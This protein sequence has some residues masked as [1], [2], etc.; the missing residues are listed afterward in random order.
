MASWTASPQP[1][2]AHP[3]VFHGE[4]L[5]EVVHLGAGGDAIRLHLSNAYGKAPLEIAGVHVAASAGG[6]STSAASDRAV[7]FRGASSVV[8]PPGGVATSDPVSL[9]V[10]PR[11]E[12]AV[13]L[14]FAGTAVATT[15]HGFAGADVYVAAAGDVAAA[16]DLSSTRTLHSWFFLSE[17]D[18]RADPGARVVVAFGDSVTD[19]MGSTN[20]S[21][22]RWPDRLS[23][24]LRGRTPRT[25]TSIVNAGIAGNRLLAKLAGDSGLARFERD[26][27]SL[28]GASTVIVMIGLNDL[29]AHAPEPESTAE[30]IIA[31][32]QKLIAMARARG[33]RVLGATLTPF[34]GGDGDGFFLP[35]DEPKRRAVNVWIRTGGAYDAVVDFDRVI[36]DPTHPTRIA[37]AFDSGDHLHPNDAGYRAMADAVDLARLGFE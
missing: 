35:A 33:L 11:S 9:R 29:G 1:A 28:P 23:E 5:R 37:P 26:V 32:H 2:G 21:N 8:M 16:P 20:G 36:A 18:V 15:F 30:E 19:G 22:H 10:E 34:E 14:F 13:S 12:V 7:L 31:G 4:T 27:L 24:R 6:A 17:V 25:S 3:E